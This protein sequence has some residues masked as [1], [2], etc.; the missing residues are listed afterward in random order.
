MREQGW[1]AQLKSA[2]QGWAAGRELRPLTRQMVKRLLVDA[3]LVNLSLALAL[4]L[5]YLVASFTQTGAFF[6]DRQLMGSFC[7]IYLKSAWILTLVAL[8]IF[9]IS[10]FYTRGSMYISR[11]KP[12]VILQ[13]VTLTYLAFGSL[14]FLA[15]ANIGL[16]RSVLPVAWL[17]TLVTI[18]GVRVAFVLVE[19]EVLRDLGATRETRVP[20]PRSVLGVGGCGK[21]YE[22]RRGSASVGT[23]LKAASWKQPSPGAT[24]GWDRSSIVPGSWEPGSMPGTRSLTCGAGSELLPRWAWTQISTPDGS[25]PWTRCCPGLTLTPVSG[26]SSWPPSVKAA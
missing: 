12:L 19:Q 15:G 13:A 10:G 23:T 14:V 22:V 16:P 26:S 3:V 1:S 20:D 25:V 9:Y 4:F 21:V 11:Y 17:L 5:R 24:G 6:V 18:G 7:T 8:A 2:V